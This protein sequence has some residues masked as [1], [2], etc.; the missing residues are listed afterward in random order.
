MLRTD[1]ILG[2]RVELSLEELSNGVLNLLVEVNR[3]VRIAVMPG[4]GARDIKKVLPS[5]VHPLLGRF[6][7]EP[8][9]EPV[10][11]SSGISRKTKGRS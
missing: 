5:D 9:D 11:E 2:T 3:N 10:A 7:T 6:S 8:L 4:A 1:S